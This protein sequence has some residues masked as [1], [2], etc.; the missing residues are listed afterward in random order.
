MNY[1][2]NDYGYMI[3][4]SMEDKIP[5]MEINYSKLK[6]FEDLEKKL[7]NVDISDFENFIYLM[8]S[9]KKDIQEEF[10]KKYKDKINIRSIIKKYE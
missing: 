2:S 8:L 3:F 4:I 1:K 10:L 9:E 7:K 5:L 6:S